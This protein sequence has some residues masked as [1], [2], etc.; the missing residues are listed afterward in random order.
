MS[1]NILVPWYMF[2]K[3]YNSMHM[4]HYSILK[5]KYIYSVLEVR[6]VSGVCI[7][8]TDLN[9][10]KLREILEKKQRALIVADESILLRYSG[11]L[12]SFILGI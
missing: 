12:F 4:A 6:L 5:A 10:Q 3:H 9:Q 1:K 11:F 8:E 2:R 7:N